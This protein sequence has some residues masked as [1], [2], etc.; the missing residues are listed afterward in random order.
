MAQALGILLPIDRGFNGYFRQGFDTLE[1]VKSNFVNLILTRLGER[2]HQPTFGC[3]IHDYLFEP[4]S[5]E[6]IE[7]A[8]LSVID[9][10]SRWMPFLQLLVVR[11][12]SLQENIDRNKLQLYVKYQLTNSPTMTDEILLTF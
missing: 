3:G 5:D 10:V 12:E 2:L 8:R 1:Q 4:M 6:N 9:A 11:I 7:L